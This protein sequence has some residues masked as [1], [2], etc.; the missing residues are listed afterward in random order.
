MKTTRLQ[1]TGMTCGHCREAVE[2]ALL[3]TTGVRNASVQ[4][5]S[6][7]AEVEYE[8]G[9]VAPE[10]LISSVEEEGYRAAIA[11]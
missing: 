9:R 4:L 10:Q 8:E 1:V 5:E 3:N 6:G 11:G 2:K 7:T